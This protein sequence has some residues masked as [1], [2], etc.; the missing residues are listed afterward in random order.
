M[1]DNQDFCWYQEMVDNLSPATFTFP[2][3]SF[4][5]A[6]P[7]AVIFNLQIYAIPTLKAMCVVGPNVIVGQCP[8]TGARTAITTVH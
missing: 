5:I 4:C 8:A 2:A 1:W 7:D 6:K 3:A